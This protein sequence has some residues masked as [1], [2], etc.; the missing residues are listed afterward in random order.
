MAQQL[1][2]SAEMTAAMLIAGTIGW[3]VLESGQPIGDVVF[4]RCLF[5]AATLLLACAA[6]GLFRK[7]LTLRT[8]AI[9]VF[10]GIA[11]VVNW[12]LLFAAFS[13]A[14]IAVATAIYNT[15]PFMLVGLGAIFFGEKLTAGKLGWLGLAFAGTLLILKDG[16]AGGSAGAEYLIG[17]AMAAGAALCYAVA[18]ASAK[19]LAGT[20]P[21]LVALIHVLV[22]VLML[23]PFADLAHP[24]AELRSWVMLAAIGV[25]HTGL[26]Y[27]LLYAAI[28]KLPTPV[29]GA[30][31]FIYP[32]VAIAT[33]YF[34][35]DH[36]LHPAQWLG[37][38]AIFLAAGGM[39]FGP[40][41]A[42]CLRRRRAGPDTTSLLVSRECLD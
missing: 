28:Q 5:G 14:S 38:G 25:V 4:W 27:I 30:I 9:A 15:Q 37:A 17:V 31:S 20:P 11:I 3:F 42:G 24:P 34:A 19:K 22:G 8:I 33:D 7:R 13:R 40:A 29:T 6:L 10:G 32:V 16:A 35:Y 1:R 21:Q 39:T 23:A 12:L 26:V 2:G 36:L 41:V 18:A